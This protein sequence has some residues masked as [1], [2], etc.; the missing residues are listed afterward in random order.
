MPQCPNLDFYLHKYF[1]T[2]I[3]LY[4]VHPGGIFLEQP[5]NPWTT[6]VKIPSSSHVYITEC[7]RVPVSSWFS[8]KPSFEI[9]CKGTL[10]PWV[11]APIDLTDLIKLELSSSKTI[12]RTDRRLS[13]YDVAKVTKS[14]SR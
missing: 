7:T 13:I 9:R 11:M 3:P 10:H 12:L 6:Y 5:W 1:K 4:Y 14:S 2:S 8:S